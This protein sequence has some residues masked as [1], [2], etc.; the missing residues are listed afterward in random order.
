MDK[1]EFVA[2][3]AKR[4]DVKADAIEQ[5]IDTTLAEVIGPAIF[6]QPGERRLLLAD[7]N[8]GNNCAAEIAR[9]QP[10]RQF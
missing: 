2:K 10:V 8:C 4:L 1:A 3:V 6:T 5:I 7:N 9:Q